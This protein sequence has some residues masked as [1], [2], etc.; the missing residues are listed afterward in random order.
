MRGEGASVTSN[1]QTK[2]QSHGPGQR[3]TLSPGPLPAISTP[4]LVDRFLD[5]IRVADPIFR[6]FGG[7]EAFRGEI[8]TVFCFED[9]TQVAASLD[10]PGNGRVLVIDGGASL[11]MALTG[12]QVL[13]RSIRNGWAGVI[14]NGCV[15]D[16]PIVR[17]LPIG[18]KALAPHPGR[19]I[20]R[21]E[22]ARDVP[23]HFA[24]VTFLPGDYV[25]ADATGIVVL[26]ASQVALLD[27][28]SADGAT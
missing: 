19:R 2:V 3:G 10:S 24:G 9:S 26:T 8:A 1:V 12:D 25:F 22:G 17:E 21:G 15:R 4:D 6:D 18:V 20:R 27:Q 7:H 28:A 14:I 13:G 23:V 16:A 5:D 11:R